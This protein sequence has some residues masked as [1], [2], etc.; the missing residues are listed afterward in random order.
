MA[1]PYAEVIGDPIAHSKSPLIHK[2]WLEKLGLSGD[3]RA[4]RVA[5]GDLPTYLS[6]RAADPDWAGSN[7]TIPHKQ[8]MMPLVQKA[9]DSAAKIGAINIVARDAE[10]SEALVGYNSDAQGFL[11]PLRPLLADQHL[12]RMARI[13]GAGGAARAVAHVLAAEGFTLVIAAR[14]VAQADALLSAVGGEHH[15]IALSH[16]AEP[17]DF[18]F[19]DRRG[20]LD[21]L[22]N[23]TPLGMAGQPPLPIHW[24]HVPPGSIVYDLVYD[25][26]ETPLLAQAR[27]RGH[28][29]ISGLDM[30]IGQAAVAFNIFFGRPA[31]RE[32]DAEL[33]GLLT[34]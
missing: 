25:P 16:F 17:T 28:L 6:G 9:A 19:D 33:R 10:G 5:A 15:A 22:V 2:F 1:V 20:L 29:T 26:V 7:V 13:F 24:S 11:E 12:F 18:L 32:H 14:D 4:T 27:A 31:P 30:L 21:L 3:Y 8:A 23:T 34:A